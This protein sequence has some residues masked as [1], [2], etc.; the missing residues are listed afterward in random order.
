MKIALT[1]KGAGLG[2]WLDDDFLH[3]SQVMV[4]DEKNHFD[5]W[6]NPHKSITDELSTL[7]AEEILKGNVDILI[8]NQIPQTSLEHLAEKGARVVS[9]SVGTVFDLLEEARNL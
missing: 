9:K 5:A 3:C 6:V 1:V 8:T 7:L 4:V 2:A